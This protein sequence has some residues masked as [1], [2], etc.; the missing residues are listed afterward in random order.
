MSVQTYLDGLREKPEHI[1]KRHAFWYAFGATAILF[2]FWLG[3][4]TGFGIGKIGMNSGGTSAAVSVSASSAASSISTPGQ[5]MVAGVGSLGKDIW[6]LIFGPKKVVY[7]E[8]EV[9]P[10]K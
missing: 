3:S 7:S 8:V 5:S 10:G 4:I 6:E 1:R 9:S 2:M